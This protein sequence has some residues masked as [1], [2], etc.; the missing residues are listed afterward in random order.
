MRAAGDGSPLTLSSLY[1]DSMVMGLL[2]DQ[3]WD[4]TLKEVIWYNNGFMRRM[5]MQWDH[6]SSLMALQAN[7]ASNGKG[8]RFQPK[9]FHPYADMYKSSSRKDVEEARE[10]FDKMKKF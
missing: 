1:R 10:L 2:P 3:F 7:I 4:M 9:D 8:K 6:T 5:A